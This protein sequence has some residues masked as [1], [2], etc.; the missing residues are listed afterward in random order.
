MTR[1]RTLVDE[2]GEEVMDGVVVVVAQRH[3]LGAL[4]V[5]SEELGPGQAWKE[6]QGEISGPDM[7][8]VGFD[9]GRAMRD[10]VSAFPRWPT[11]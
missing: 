9:V 8:K 4:G 2:V 5:R 3:D 1:C 7:V 10:G 6:Q 11:H